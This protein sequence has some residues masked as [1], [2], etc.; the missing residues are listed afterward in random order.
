MV[1]GPQR[2]GPWCGDCGTVSESGR[3]Q[4]PTKNS[5]EPL[6]APDSGNKGHTV[7]RE[8]T[9]QTNNAEMDYRPMCFFFH[10]VLAILNNVTD[11]TLLPPKK[12]FSVNLSSKESLPLLLNFNNKQ[13]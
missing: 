2:R 13:M 3:R 1:P 12:R 11:K 9:S 4:G 10:H 5:A 7:C 6:S 8:L